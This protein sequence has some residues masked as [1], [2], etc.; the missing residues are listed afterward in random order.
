MEFRYNG[1]NYKMPF[2]ETRH[3]TTHYTT[4]VCV[5]FIAATAGVPPFSTCKD[6]FYGAFGR[7]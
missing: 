4:G 1:I 5:Y 2:L 7:H 6:R 3:D